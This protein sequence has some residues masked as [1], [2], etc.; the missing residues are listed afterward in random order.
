MKPEIA[1]LTVAVVLAAIAVLHVYWGVAGIPGRSV[2]IPEVDGKP[3][4]R[5]T[6]GA[7]FAVAGALAVAVYLLL[8]GAGALPAVGPA[9]LGTVAPASRSWIPASTPRSA[10][11]WDWP[12]S[13]PSSAGGGETR[14]RFPGR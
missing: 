1:A 7:C 3:L 10:S 13:G 11:C 12:R 5:P 8:L 9:W 2:A 14:A 6:R 4:F